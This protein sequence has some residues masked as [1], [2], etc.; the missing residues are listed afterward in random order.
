MTIG[1]TIAGLNDLLRSTFMTGG[2]LVTEG[3]RAL[4][5]GTQSEI[6]TRVRSFDAFTPDNDPHG[7]HDFGYLDRSWTR[8]D[9]CR[10]PPPGCRFALR[11][12]SRPPNTH[13]PCRCVVTDDENE[14]P[15]PVLRGS[16]NPIEL[17]G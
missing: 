8:A 6:L 1:I 3:I 4:P 11:R 10:C 13:P 5:A 14:R 12:G 7:E 9:V 2:V 16:P 15:S 17:T